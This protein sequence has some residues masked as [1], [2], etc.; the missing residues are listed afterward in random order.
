MEV[1]HNRSIAGNERTMV[2]SN[3]YENVKSLNIWAV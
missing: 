3:L 2:G 1:D